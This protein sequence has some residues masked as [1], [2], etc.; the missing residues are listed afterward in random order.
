M[1]IANNTR[2]NFTLNKLPLISSVMYK[3]S[4]GAYAFN[5]TLTHHDR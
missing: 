1:S 4:S 2:P 5:I 3:L